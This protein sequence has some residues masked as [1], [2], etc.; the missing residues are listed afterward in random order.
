MMEV[1]E[2]YVV[3]QNAGETPLRP[4]LGHDVSS[5]GIGLSV[6]GKSWREECFDRTICRHRVCVFP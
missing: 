5:V 3:V 1:V 6:D 4:E 2:T